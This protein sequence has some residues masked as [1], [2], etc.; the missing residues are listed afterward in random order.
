MSKL[1]VVKSSWTST[2]HNHRNKSEF[3][4]THSF[5]SNLWSVKQHHFF[6]LP[7]LHILCKI[8]IPCKNVQ[9]HCAWCNCSYFCCHPWWVSSVLKPKCFPCLFVLEIWIHFIC[10]QLEISAQGRI[11]TK[12]E[13]HNDT[14]KSYG[15]IDMWILTV[16]T[17]TYLLWSV[18]PP[19]WRIQK[20]L[21]P[22]FLSRTC[23]RD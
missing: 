8:L 12:R 7:I 6:Q 14:N 13:R 15:F 21:L 18:I 9:L 22:Q 17:F 1:T 16:L 5:S 4:R 20:E 2:C 10:L 19:S 11:A 3:V 23:C